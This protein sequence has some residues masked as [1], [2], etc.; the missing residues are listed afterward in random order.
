MRTHGVDDNTFSTRADDF[1]GAKTWANDDASGQV[2]GQ[3]GSSLALA[4]EV[5]AKSNS[6]FRRYPS[7]IGNP[8]P[9]AEYYFTIGYR[10]LTY[11]YLLA[12]KE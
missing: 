4:D 8:E 10:F 3:T 11:F 6:N 1:T 7:R 2:N 9:V 5:M 12:C